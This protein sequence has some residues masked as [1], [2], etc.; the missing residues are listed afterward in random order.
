M[1]NLNDKMNELADTYEKNLDLHKEDYHS[2]YKTGFQA[3]IVAYS[4]HLAEVETLR[5]KL[6]AFE[7]MTFSE[8]AELTKL[9]EQNKAMRLAIEHYL[10][11][12]KFLAAPDEDTCASSND[13]RE[14]L[15]GL[16]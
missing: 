9:T 5:N 11:V 14:C 13:F 10:E 16:E 8:N 12:Q 1:T 4:D 3:A 15:K 7:G 2:A 6:Q